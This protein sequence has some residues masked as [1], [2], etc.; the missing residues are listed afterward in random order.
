MQILT[1]KEP[2]LPPVPP[3]LL[4]LP[5]NLEISNQGSASQCGGLRNYKCAQ[6]TTENENF[7][8]DPNALYQNCWEETN[9]DDSSS[10]PR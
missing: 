8:A 10:E 9:T 2:W 7:G 3:K 1:R 5:E 6:D 4:Y